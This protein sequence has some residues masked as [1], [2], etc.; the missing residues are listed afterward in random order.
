MGRERHPGGWSATVGFTPGVKPRGT[1]LVPPVE[2]RREPPFGP[3]G[4][5]ESD[6]CPAFGRLRPGFEDQFER[7]DV[8]LVGDDRVV[9]DDVIVRVRRTLAG[10]ISRGDQGDLVLAGRAVSGRAVGRVRVVSRVPVRVVSRVVC[11]VVVSVAIGTA[12]EGCAAD[13]DEEGSASHT[14]GIAPA[15]G[16]CLQIHAGTRL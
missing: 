4:E 15:G 9:T 11:R 2:V 5:L 6:R 12:R 10:E 8:T 14:I 16:I 3:V 13:G 7:P 1:R